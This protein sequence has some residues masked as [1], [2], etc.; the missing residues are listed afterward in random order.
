MQKGVT[1]FSNCLQRVVIVFFEVLSN[2][3]VLFFLFSF[4]KVAGL[5]RLVE[6]PANLARVSS[7][8]LATPP[9]PAA[10]SKADVSVKKRMCMVVCAFGDAV[11][12]S[13]GCALMLVFVN[14]LRVCVCVAHCA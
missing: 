14:C 8:P 12:L 3:F 13:K 4:V 2:F 6:A 10:L 11:A 7:A 1:C 5:R 9:M